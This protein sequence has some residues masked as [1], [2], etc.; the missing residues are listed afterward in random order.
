M[1]FRYNAIDVAKFR[2]VYNKCLLLLASAT[3]SVESY[4]AAQSGKYELCTLSKRYGNAVLPD[5]I[6]VDMRTAE[7]AHGSKALSLTLFEALKEN[8][9]NGR[10]SILLINRR[11]FHTFAACNV[12]SEVICCPHCSISMTYHNANNRLMCHYCGYSQH[13]DESCPDCAGELRYIGAGT[14]MVE[15]ELAELFPGTEILR[16]DT[17]TVT[18]A[19]SHQK[20]LDKFRDENI[21]TKYKNITII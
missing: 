1:T 3:P 16:M 2:A 4:A 21:F 7:K 8:F 12:C 11:G 14:Q 15:S 9:E 13:P 10:Q 20:L 5:V 6:T 17:D 18:A 19:G